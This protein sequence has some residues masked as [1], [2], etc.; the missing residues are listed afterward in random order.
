MRSLPVAGK[1]VGSTVGL[2]N[3]ATAVRVAVGWVV[4]VTCAVGEIGRVVAVTNSV[5]VA[6]RVAVG[7]VVVVTCA[8]GE[9]CWDVAVAEG[10]P[11]I[12]RVAVAVSVSVAVDVASTV[13]VCSG[14]SKGDRVRVAAGVRVRVPV[15]RP[16]VDGKVGVANTRRVGV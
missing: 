7:W 12:V 16:V 6:V 8:V 15:T 10:V 3:S 5:P 4:V 11:V 13:G 1:G 2:A 14:L 9:I